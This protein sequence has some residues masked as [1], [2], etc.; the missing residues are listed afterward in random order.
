M[1]YV[2]PNDDACT[3]FEFNFTQD[4]SCAS[5]KF[6][7]NSRQYIEVQLMSFFLILSIISGL[8]SVVGIYL[9]QL[10]NTRSRNQLSTLLQIVLGLTT[11]IMTFYAFGN[12]L[13]SKANGGIIGED[14][15]LGESY[16]HDHSFCL[17][18]NYAMLVILIQSSCLASSVHERMSLG[19]YIL[20]NFIMQSSVFPLVA[21]WT[22]GKGWLY[23]L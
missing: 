22:A 9:I 23:R 1:F 8:L 3:K 2:P 16:G 5:Y 15:Y 10:G 11:S 7:D 20:F 19:S 13:F 6:Y 21:S 18:W 14:E 12:S 4:F 17:E